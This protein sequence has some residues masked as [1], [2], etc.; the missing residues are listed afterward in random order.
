MNTTNQDEIEIALFPIPGCVCFP[1]TIMP[2]HVFEP[3]YRAMI[4]DCVRLGRPIG[5]SH[6][7]KE[8]S[9]VKR[10]QTRAEILSSNQ[11]TY[12]AQK[13]FSAGLAEIEDVTV[14]GR[15][16]VIIRMESRYESLEEIQ[17]LPYRIDRCRIY[18]DAEVNAIEASAFKLKV[19]SKLRNQVASSAKEIQDLF[20]PA[21]WD[22]VSFEE[23][24]FRIFS[25][26]RVETELSQALLE[27]RSPEA[28]IKSLLRILEQNETTPYN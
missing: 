25:V 27:M 3:R 28:R 14:D 9:S 24:S 22:Q 10:T 21:V 1:Q 7:V 13:V 8:I 5:V 17:T 6:T 12:Q 15:M 4:K 26:V 23:F 19:L 2:L 20:A 16:G 11:E 18:K